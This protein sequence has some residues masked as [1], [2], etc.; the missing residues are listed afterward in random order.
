MRTYLPVLGASDPRKG[1]RSPPA[2]HTP[3]HPLPTINPIHPHSPILETIDAACLPQRYGGTDPL[4]LGDAPEEKAFREY[5]DKVNAGLIA[6]PSAPQQPEQAGEGGDVETGAVAAAVPPAGAR[7]SAALPPL[8]TL[9]EQEEQEQE[10]QRSLAGRLVGFGQGLGQRA[11]GVAVGTLRRLRP[12]FLTP[13]TPAQEANLGRENRFVYDRERGQWVLIEEEVEAEAEEAAEAGQ[14]EAAAA[15]EDEEERLVRAIQ[16][17]HAPGGR[18]VSISKRIV[19]ALAA[20]GVAAGVASSAAAAA[21]TDLEE[22]GGGATGPLTGAEG[23]AKQQQAATAATAS[24][25]A[26]PA[27]LRERSLSAGSLGSSA[28]SSA[29][30][31][32]RH[33]SCIGS[34]LLVLMVA[35]RALAL[36]ILTALPL[37]LADAGR[38]DATPARIAVLFA[39]GALLAAGLRALHALTPQALT[40]FA[41]SLWTMAALGAAL[42][43]PGPLTSPGTAHSAAYRTHAIDALGAIVAGL[44]LLVHGGTVA[45]AVHLS[46]STFKK[47]AHRARYDLAPAMTLADVAGAVAGPLLYTVGDTYGRVEV[48]VDAAALWR[49]PL[50]ATAWFSVCAILAGAT[51]LYLGGC[52]RPFLRPPVAGAAG[53][54]RM[55]ARL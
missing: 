9:Q 55:G 34:T 4:E 29:A 31:R 32:R 54:S 18:A 21:P 47:E 19:Q 33:K 49:Y 28:A 7:A 30:A 40:P 46:K 16:A 45:W 35:W 22:G 43:L 17:A 1:D 38:R 8:P 41:G 13:L 44:A 36:S 2:K 3:P 42:A 51:L 6:P 27:V 53:G 20:G 39:L 12:A 11:A 37:W 23:G 26:A 15:E 24:A 48:D 5:T 25:S 10:Q 50:G 52:G 14:G